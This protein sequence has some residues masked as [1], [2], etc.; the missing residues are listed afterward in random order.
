M[1]CELEGEE[2]K[3]RLVAHEGA[4]YSEAPCLIRY[5]DEDPE[6]GIFKL[7]GQLPDQ[8]PDILKVASQ[9]PSR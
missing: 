5:V 9:Y 2:E 3:A 8:S 7:G 6:L 4:N 1:A